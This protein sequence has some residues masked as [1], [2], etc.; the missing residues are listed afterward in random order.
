MYPNNSRT[1]KSIKTMPGYLTGTAGAAG[2]GVLH[3]EIVGLVPRAATWAGMEMELALRE[4][5][6]TLE[7]VYAARTVEPAP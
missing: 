6:R 7:G 4:P 1:N 5:V 3:S 2:T